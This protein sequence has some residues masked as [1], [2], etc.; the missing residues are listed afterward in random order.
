M[1]TGALSYLNALTDTRRCLPC[2]IVIRGKRKYVN[3]HA[4]QKN[5]C[6]GGVSRHPSCADVQ[7]QRPQGSEKPRRKACS[8][9][10]QKQ[11]GR[12][13]GWPQRAYRKISKG[14]SDTLLA[15]GIP[16]P[17]YPTMLFECA[18]KNSFYIC[19]VIP[20]RKD[21][22]PGTR[23]RSPPWPSMIFRTE[24]SPIP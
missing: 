12:G 23:S 22:S 1:P 15:Y 5:F 21:F 20:T 24:E 19:I 9:D 18:S 4:P 11:A 3:P 14:Y 6:Y 7:E 8:P 17:G 13:L 10:Q 16:N 2:T